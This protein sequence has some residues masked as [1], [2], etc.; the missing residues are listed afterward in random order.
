MANINVKTKK[1]FWDLLEFY[2]LSPR[3]NR[4]KYIGLYSFWFSL[5]GL[6]VILSKSHTTIGGILVLIILPNFI[7]LYFRRLNDLN[8]SAWWSL[9]GIIPIV[10]GIFQL[11]TFLIPGTKKANKYGARPEKAERVYLYMLLL[12]PVVVYVYGLCD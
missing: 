11:F 12:L 2:S 3:I 7:A 10:G 5:L 6:I 9:I 4:T 1:S 8:L